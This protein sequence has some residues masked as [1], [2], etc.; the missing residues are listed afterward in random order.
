MR[1]SARCLWLLTALFL[2]RVIAQP[3]SLFVAGPWLPPFESYQSGLVPYPM[4]LLSQFLILLAMVGTSWRA[5]SGTLMPR[6]HLGRVLL[7]GGWIYFASMLVRLVIGLFVLRESSFFAKPLPT[8]FHL[9]LASFLIVCGRIHRAARISEW[10]GR[11]R[12]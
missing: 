12:R 7:I 1:W 4:L 11:S 9:V 2:L 5:S 6:P 10:L 3:L 8:F